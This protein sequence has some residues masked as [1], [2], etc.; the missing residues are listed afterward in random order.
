[1]GRKH[2]PEH[3]VPSP[4]ASGPA[5][6]QLPSGKDPGKAFLKGDVCSHLALQ[7]PLD[8]RS[9]AETSEQEETVF[10]AAC[11][12]LTASEICWDGASA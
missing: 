4:L 7:C 3:T 6:R 8:S 2:L 9:A 11:K 10:V 1:M 5:S 12:T